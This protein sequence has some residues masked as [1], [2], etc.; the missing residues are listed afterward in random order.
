MRF[1]THSLSIGALAVAVSH[2]S[3]C[4]QA[5][6]NWGHWRGPLQNGVAPHADPP[7]RWSEKENVRWR[8]DVPGRGHATPVVWG[9]RVYLTTAIPFGEKVPPVPDDAP[10]AHDNAPVDRHH[11]FAALAVDRK[12]GK[13]LWKTSLFKGLPHAGAHKSGTLASNSPATDGEHLYASFGSVGMFCLDRNGKIVWRRDLGDMQ[14]KHGHGEGSSPV[15]AGDLIAV[16][17]DHEGQSFLVALDKKTGKDRWRVQRNEVVDRPADQGHRFDRCPDK[18][19]VGHARVPGPE[20]P[21]AVALEAIPQ[22]PQSPG[23]RGHR[24]RV[25]LGVVRGGPAGIV[26]GH[27]PAAGDRFPEVLLDGETGEATEQVSCA[28]LVGD[29]KRRQCVGCLVA[30]RPILARRPDPGR[31]NN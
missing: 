4:A 15:V 8:F 10:G 13:L 18:A 25:G 31:R 5:D 1:T 27:R 21:L 3:L 19:V 26:G 29:E 17:W 2:P 12:T 24:G 11:D 23:D 22:V 30:H 9:D 7:L 14:V 16:N 20:G 6:K 28:D